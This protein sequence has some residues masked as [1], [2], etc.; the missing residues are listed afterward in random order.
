MAEKAAAI[1]NLSRRFVPIPP[2]VTGLGASLLEPLARWRNRPPKFAYMIHY[3]ANRFL[4]Y[5]SGKA[6][7]ELNYHPR[8]FDAILRSEAVR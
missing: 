1:M 4:Y 8:D 3:C 2:V 6:R 5:D 7:A